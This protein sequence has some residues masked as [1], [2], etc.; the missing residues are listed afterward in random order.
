M[1]SL[2]ARMEIERLVPG[3]M[4]KSSRRRR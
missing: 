4:A 3:V 1:G 2:E